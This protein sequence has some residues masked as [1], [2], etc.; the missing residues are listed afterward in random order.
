M[1][2]RHF[3]FN[4][5][6][7]QDKKCRR[8][9]QRLLRI[10]DQKSVKLKDLEQITEEYV[11]TYAKMDSQIKT[12]SKKHQELMK[13]FAQEKSENRCLIEAIQKV[14]HEK[15][16]L[17]ERWIKLSNKNKTEDKVKNKLK[18]LE[19]S[20][21]YKD[22]V[23]MNQFSKI[24]ELE[25]VNN[26]LKQEISSNNTFIEDAKA[27]EIEIQKINNARTK[28]ME[29][30]NEC[31]NKFDEQNNAYKQDL[32]KV[33]QTNAQMADVINQYKTD[34]DEITQENNKLKQMWS[35]L[36]LKLKEKESKANQELIK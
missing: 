25:K 2:N 8:H 33:E 20:N 9:E 24:E 32:I 26:T 19:T 36:S 23:I 5:F 3:L 10:I 28:A 1:L 7:W 29:K 27:K 17:S 11:S 6:S 13:K 22:K 16:K 15:L 4:N 30:L 14:E 34:I 31:N 21:E 18:E 35:D 12:M